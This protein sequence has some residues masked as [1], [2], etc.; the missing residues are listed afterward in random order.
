[1]N[2]IRQYV[3]A[4]NSWDH[5]LVLPVNLMLFM[6]KAPASKQAEFRREALHALSRE[7]H[8]VQ[9]LKEIGENKD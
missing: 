2:I 1:M 3:L 4:E 9:A 8:V 5:P 7:C 6:L